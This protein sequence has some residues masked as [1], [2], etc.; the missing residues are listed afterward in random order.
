MIYGALAT[1]VNHV[2]RGTHGH[3]P[4][5]TSVPRPFGV[6]PLPASGG[7]PLPAVR[8]RSSSIIN[9]LPAPA[10]TDAQII[11]PRLVVPQYRGRRRVE[12]RTIGRELLEDVAQSR[13]PRGPFSTR[14]CG[15]LPPMTGRSPPIV[16]AITTAA[17]TRKL[18]RCRRIIPRVR[19]QSSS[20]F[21]RSVERTVKRI[22]RRR[23]RPGRRLLGPQGFP[24]S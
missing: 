15:P 13:V 10:K 2:V 4:A 8:R 20:F 14:P 6:G 5:Q 18:Q 9:R 23:I 22:S 16:D 11:F 21:G 3:P 17:G 24:S 19:D 12:V 7:S 1:G